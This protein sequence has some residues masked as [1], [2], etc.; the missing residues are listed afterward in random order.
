MKVREVSLLPRITYILCGFCI[1]KNGRSHLQVSCFSYSYLPSM[2]ESVIVMSL[3]HQMGEMR[4][5][6]K[7]LV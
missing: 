6:Y 3:T 1:V 7:I 2:I 4:N 5:A